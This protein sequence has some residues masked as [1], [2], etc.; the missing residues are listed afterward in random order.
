MEERLIDFYGKKKPVLFTHTDL[1]GLGCEV[2][3][4]TFIGDRVYRCEPDTVSDTILSWMEDKKGDEWFVFITDLCPTLDVLQSLVK[5]GFNTNVYDH[6]ATNKYVEDELGPNPFCYPVINPGTES[7]PE[8][9]TSVFL[10]NQSGRMMGS[11]NFAKNNWLYAFADTV[12]SYDT[13]EWKKTNNV[14][15]KNLQTLLFT[16]GPDLFV[17]HYVKRYDSIDKDNQEL[18]DPLYM[19]II[20]A[21]SKSEEKAMTDFIE[22]GTWYN[23]NIRGYKGALVL[24]IPS[25]N[26]SDL[27]TYFL[28]KY[29]NYDII[30]YLLHGN[31]L[32]Y[33][34]IR[35]D[36]DLGNDI[37][38]PIGGG[39]HPKA[40]GATL[41]DRTM[42]QIVTS[43][44]DRMNTTISAFQPQ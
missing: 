1:D 42:K 35:D 41:P 15:A 22:N 25:C 13:F 29:T 23:V 9:G 20:E 28:K 10:S 18:I 44:A 2:L 16:L 31:T 8:S 14:D 37:C 4:K 34:T 17:E 33:R 12:R 5:H 36:I 21:K 27:A 7:R 11:S 26:I 40:A 19:E 43:I 6:H 38:K 32:S 39:G 24:D 3:F 30:V